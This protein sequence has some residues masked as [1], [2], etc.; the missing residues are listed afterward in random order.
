MFEGTRGLNTVIWS[1]CLCRCPE[2]PKRSGRGGLQGSPRASPARFPLL[3][4]RTRHPQGCAEVQLEKW[5][6]RQGL[7]LGGM[8]KR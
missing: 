6:P 4:N 7:E 2:G 5:E 1:F 8:G 3:L